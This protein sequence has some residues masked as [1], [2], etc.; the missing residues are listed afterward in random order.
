MNIYRKHFFDQLLPVVQEA[1]IDLKNNSEYFCIPY[2]EE[3]GDDRRFYVYEWYTKNPEMVF[4]VGRGT[5]SR[6]KHII[7]DMNR[8]RGELY[9][10]F[11]E[12]FGIEHRIVLSGLTD[13]EASI[14]EI[15]QIW[16]RENE[17]EVLIQFENAFSY[18]KGHQEQ[19]D[20][21]KCGIVPDIWI[22]PVLK[23]Y[24]PE[25]V[26]GIPKYDKIDGTILL[27]AY[28]IKDVGEEVQF[29]IDK[30]ESL[31]GKVYKSLAKNAKCVIE[32]R[33]TSYEKYIEY[34]DRGYMIYHLLD[35]IDYFS[36]KDFD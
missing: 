18:W 8:P 15:Y 13:Q 21:V 26:S 32:T 2:L 20:K 22:S 4:Y 12:K 33:V 10:E 7:T 5:G 27:N 14:Y 23:R 1:Y 9:K 11:Q 36:N 34:K 19:C 30:I 17:G 28:I 16:K 6:Y 25:K 31:G 24:F 3:N 35:V 29:V